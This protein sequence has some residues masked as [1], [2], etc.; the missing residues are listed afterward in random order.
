[1]KTNEW[2]LNN[3]FKNRIIN[4]I[5]NCWNWDNGHNKKY[6]RVSYRGRMIKVSRLI[7]YLEKGFDLDSPLKILHHCDNPKCFNPEHLFIGS[8]LENVIDMYNKGR[9]FK[10]IRNQ[11]LFQFE[12]LEIRKFYKE[13]WKIKDIAKMFKISYSR[14][15]FI[16]NN[17]NWNILR[18]E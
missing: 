16:I 11:K 9:G 3:L 15:Y 5:T 10:G 6:G 12:V 1:M 18:D 4:P 2:F 17:P 8:Q 13:G 14:I 7:M